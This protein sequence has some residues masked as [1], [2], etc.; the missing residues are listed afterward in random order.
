MARLGNH[1]DTLKAHLGAIG[2]YLG[3]PRNHLVPWGTVL[4]A[5]GLHFEIP[6]APRGS[7]L[8]ILQQICKI[9]ENH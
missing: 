7:I 1:W 9:H 2:P 4:D 5:P 6:G 8:S 3:A